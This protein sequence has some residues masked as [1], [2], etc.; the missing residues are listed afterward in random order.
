MNE[1]LDHHSEN[2]RGLEGCY[3]GM[4][5]NDVM[6]ERSLRQIEKMRQIMKMFLTGCLPIIF[7]LCCLA[8]LEGWIFQM[9]WNWLVPLFW[10]SAPILTFWQAYGVL[11]LINI[12]TYPIRNSNKT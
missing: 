6:F 5:Y 1:R 9:L 2:Y 3:G 8:A 7:I 10:S 12:I 11:I 4:D